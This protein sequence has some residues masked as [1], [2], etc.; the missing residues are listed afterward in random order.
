MQADGGDFTPESIN[1][2][3]TLQREGD[4]FMYFGCIRYIKSLKKGVPFFESSPMLHDISHL[5][6]W[7][8]VA[9]GLLRLYEGEVLNKRQVVQHFVF[10]NIFSA[11]WEPSQ[12]GEREA[13][14]ST[15]RHGQPVAP[16]ARAP[17]ADDSKSGMPPTKA[18]WAK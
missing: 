8:K 13:P 5:L 10:G 14:T 2:D 3:A 4:Q 1:D 6:S 11:D 15:F 18:P 16:M 17:W 7:S 9:S 12:Q